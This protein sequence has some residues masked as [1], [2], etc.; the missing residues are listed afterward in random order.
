MR[1]GPVVRA[2][3]FV[4]YPL[5]VY[6]ALEHVQAK[7]LGIAL[8][9][10]LLLRYRGRA[11]RLA[12]GMNR[13]AWGIAIAASC[14]AAI[15]WWSN[16]ELLLRMYPALLNVIGLMFF[17][18]TL[19]YPPSMIERFARLQG[20]ALS[21]D[22]VRY[23][24]RVTWVWCAFFLCNGL[25]AT[26]TALYSTREVWVLYNG[27]FAYCLMGVL[28]AGEWLVRRRFISRESAP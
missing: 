26:Y 28:F 10:V 8:L 4:V 16:D 25:A 24:E 14:F 21:A 3:P 7:Y 23:T 6:F 5:I 22:G 15:V 20:N 19:L 13:W 2:A 9:F 1:W 11:R 17:G 18:H 27:L 12:S